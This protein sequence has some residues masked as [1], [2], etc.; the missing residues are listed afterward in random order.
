MR[1]GRI[2]VHR[3]RIHGPSLHPFRKAS[4]ERSIDKKTSGRKL[5]QIVKIGQDDLT[6]SARAQQVGLL[7]APL[8]RYTIT[9]KRRG[10]LFG[11]AGYDTAAL[12]KAAGVL[13]TL[14]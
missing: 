11:Y 3:C 4:G 7:L 1:K 2:L 5:N 8:S 12:R 13:G 14:L 10:W 6:L 9:S